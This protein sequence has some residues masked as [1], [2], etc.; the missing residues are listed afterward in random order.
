MSEVLE[1]GLGLVMVYLF[2]LA[3]IM[4]MYLLGDWKTRRRLKRIDEAV[5]MNN[6]AM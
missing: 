3:C 4:T 1:F 2:F 5:R 6:D